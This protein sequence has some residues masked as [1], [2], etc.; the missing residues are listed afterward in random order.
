MIYLHTAD[1]TG[2]ILVAPTAGAPRSTRASSGQSS[3]NICVG[4]ASRADQLCA[5]DEDAGTEADQNE[6]LQASRKVTP[7]Q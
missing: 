4:A 1:L 7:E 3:P 2:L 5:H 6:L